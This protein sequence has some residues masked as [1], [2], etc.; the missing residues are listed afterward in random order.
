MTDNHR[1]G[2]Y[3]PGGG[4]ARGRIV[5]MIKGHRFAISFSAIP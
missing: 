2:A 1:I 3:Y 4:M 5:G